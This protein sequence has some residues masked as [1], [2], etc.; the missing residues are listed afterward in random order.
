MSSKRSNDWLRD[1][2][3]V[4]RIV[5]YFQN[6][7]SSSY[8]YIYKKRVSYL[9]LKAKMTQVLF[10]HLYFMSCPCSRKKEIK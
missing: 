1:I 4:I 2:I 6:C 5:V 7:L 8:S 10:E 9:Y 3:I